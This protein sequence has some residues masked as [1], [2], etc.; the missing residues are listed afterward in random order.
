V[1]L[2]ETVSAAT[3]YRAADHVLV[4]EERPVVTDRPDLLTAAWVLKEPPSRPTAAACSARRRARIVA[5]TPP[6]LD[7]RRRAMV[8]HAG[9]A[10]PALVLAPRAAPGT[11]AA[12]Y[13]R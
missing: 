7:G 12:G 13:C 5:L 10:M 3:V 1:D 11:G 6:V 8:R 4:P 2:C 9:T